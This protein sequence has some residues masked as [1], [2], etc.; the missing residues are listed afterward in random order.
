M[1]AQLN[2]DGSGHKPSRFPEIILDTTLAELLVE[3]SNGQGNETICNFKPCADPR[4]KT[5]P[6]NKKFLITSTQAGNDDDLAHL[7][8]ENVSY[9]LSFW[10]GDIEVAMVA[11]EGLSDDKT[12]MREV[13]SQNAQ[14]AF[15]ALNE[16]QRPRAR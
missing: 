16:K 14:R 10:T 3:D 7:Q 12:L 13:I 1:K 8:L 5:V 11:C 6:L 15:S 9:L 4:H 2:G